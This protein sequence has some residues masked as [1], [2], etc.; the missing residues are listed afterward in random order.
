MC[1]FISRHTEKSAEKLPA[2][3]TISRQAFVTG[4]TFVLLQRGIHS[5]LGIHNWAPLLNPLLGI[6][7][8]CVPWHLKKWSL[9]SLAPISEMLDGGYKRPYAE[10][11]QDGV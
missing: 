10:N 6:I 8:T 11:R 2:P 5:R 1:T 4:A 9:Y 7:S 3:R